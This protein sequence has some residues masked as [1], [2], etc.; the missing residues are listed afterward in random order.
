MRARLAV[1]GG[2]WLACGGAT[3]GRINPCGPCPAETLISA[4]AELEEAYEEA[5]NDP[6]FKVCAV[7]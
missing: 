7:G 4:L 1:W 6:A 2:A 5:K 3:C